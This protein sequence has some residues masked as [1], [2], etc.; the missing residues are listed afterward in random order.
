MGLLILFGLPLAMIGIGLL[1]MC[2][3][4]DHSYKLITL[5]GEEKA[6]YYKKHLD[7]N[8]PIKHGISVFLAICCW[9]SVAGLLLL[10]F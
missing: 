3:S 7:R 4:N 6:V 9:G 1:G 2:F 8:Y 5:K 10:I